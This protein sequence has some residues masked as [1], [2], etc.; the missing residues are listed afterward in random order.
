MSEP[1]EGR[2]K[3]VL[4]AALA[5]AGE[6]GWTPSLIQEA[7]AAAGDELGAQTLLFP[8][9]LT[10][11]LTFYSR[12]CDA[13]MGEQLAAAPLSQMKIRERINLGI[14]TRLTLLE[15]YE[16]AARRAGAL[17]MLPPYAP[18]GLKL[19]Y[20]TMDVL[21]RAI[22]DKSTDFNFYT[23]RALA[24]GVYLATFAV[25]LR[26]KTDGK[27]E[28][29]AVLAKHIDNVMVIEGAKLQIRKLAAILP[30][31]WG[32]LGALRYPGRKPSSDH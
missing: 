32:I 12:Q 24:V 3:A 4:E 10:D 9:G 8:E 28:A 1:L 6:M 22:G 23:K 25:W 26:D 18:L 19:A 2:R 20:E 7:V 21:W 16:S 13:A 14:R 27:A 15:P 31:P 5:R 17:L 29:W 11:L 30:S